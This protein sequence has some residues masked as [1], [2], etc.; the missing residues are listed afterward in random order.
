MPVVS[1]GSCCSLAYCLYWLVCSSCIGFAP[2]A[3]V[4]AFLIG[5]AVTVLSFCL[6]NASC[7]LLAHPALYFCNKVPHAWKRNI[8]HCD[9]QPCASGLMPQI[10]HGIIP[11]DCRRYIRIRPW[12]T[13]RFHRHRGVV[14]QKWLPCT[15]NLKSIL[16]VLNA[17][18]SS[19]G[20]FSCRHRTICTA[21]NMVSG[22][23]VRGRRQIS[24]R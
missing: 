19:P 3:A 21:I 15:D 2:S 8:K 5:D 23:Y 22:G 13:F 24:A 18:A 16:Q 12:S 4:M 11:P 10:L 20:F 9:V 1:P 14:M 7:R 6:S 17:Y